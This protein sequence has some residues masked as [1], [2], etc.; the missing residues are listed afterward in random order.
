LHLIPHL[1]RFYGGT[2]ISER[3]IPLEIYIMNLQD[4]LQYQMNSR[5]Y[6]MDHRLEFHAHSPDV[7][8]ELQMII[9]LE[10]LQSDLMVIA[11]SSTPTN[12]S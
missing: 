12:T 7:S 3:R 1:S 5:Y 8:K 4:K 6:S 9:S 11:D 2:T 10:A